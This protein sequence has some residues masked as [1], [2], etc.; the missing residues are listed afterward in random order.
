MRS[1]SNWCFLKGRLDH[2]TT[3]TL[4]NGQ[5]MS[6]VHLRLPLGRP[7]ETSVMIISTTTWNGELARLAALP[8]GTGLQITAHVSARRWMAGGV[9]RLATEIQLDSCAV[10][11]GDVWRQ[12]D[13]AAAL[14]E[15]AP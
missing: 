3:R 8:A 5:Q 11:I 9:E 10:D 15:K 4:A 6:E 1:C 13:S 12:T 14:T 7:R 2:V